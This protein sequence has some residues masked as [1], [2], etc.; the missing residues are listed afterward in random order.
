MGGLTRWLAAISTLCV[1]APPRRVLSA[2]SAVDQAFRA[3]D[4][5]GRGTRQ[6]AAR[7]DSLC[8]PDFSFF[9]P[10]VLAT[11]AS[12]M[13]Q[14]Q[15]LAMGMSLSERKKNLFAGHCCAFF[16]SSRA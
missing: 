16:L 13:M 1:V 14:D 12:F 8:F 6:E 5:S 10:I 4:V 2:E 3:G 9:S 7:Q 11:G 15:R